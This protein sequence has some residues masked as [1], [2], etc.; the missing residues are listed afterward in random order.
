MLMLL[1]RIHVVYVPR[2]PCLTVCSVLFDVL[3]VV[4]YT[5][6]L[7]VLVL[8]QIYATTSSTFQRKNGPLGVLSK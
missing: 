7:R 2:D 6:R 1:Y 4:I 5:A 3:P 8:L